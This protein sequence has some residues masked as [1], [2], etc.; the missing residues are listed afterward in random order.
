MTI[1][2]AEKEVGPFSIFRSSV[3]HIGSMLPGQNASGYGKKIST[4]YVLQFKG[5]K[6]KYRV[7]CI[8]FSN[9]GS[10]YIIRKGRKLYTGTI[11]QGDI[12]EV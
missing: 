11:L 4:D 8:C 10:T 9:A 3:R 5:E 1:M 2:Y 6:K 12:K 7:Y